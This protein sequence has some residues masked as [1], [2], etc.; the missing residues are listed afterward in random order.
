[1][2][3]DDNNV[4]NS[5][6]TVQEEDNFSMKDFMQLC[7]RQWPWFLC[8]L[9]FFIGFGL[10]YVMRQQPVYE[11]KCEVLI[12][13]NEQNSFGEVSSGFSMSGV[14]SSHT[15]VNNELISLTTPAVM[16]EVV[17]RLD[18]DM[19]YNKKG[20]LHPTT[21]YRSSNPII[22]EMPD[23][24]SEGSGGF[25]VELNPDGSAIMYKFWKYD[26]GAKKIVK[27]DKE[28]ACRLG[29][30]TLNTPI[31]RVSLQPN[32]GFTGKLVEPIDIKVSH[33]S[34]L[35]T[36]E[37]YTAR[38]NGDL[39]DQD[40]EVIELSLRDV[41][42]QRAD[43]ILD[44]VV[45]VYNE[46]WIADK[47]RVAVATSEF[48]D[49]RLKVIE[50][51]LGNV[52][53][54]V[55][56]FKA[57]NKMPDIEH[58]IEM[59]LKGVGDIATAVI[60][61]RNQLAMAQ[62]LKEYI[63]NPQHANDVVPLNIGLNDASMSQSINEFNKRLLERNAMVENSSTDNPLVKSADVE[64]RGL[65]KSILRSVD[66]QIGVLAASLR[67]IQGEQGNQD[68]MLE[69]A[70][71]QAKY[72][73]SIERQQK[74]KEELYVFLLQKREENELS[75]TFTAYNTRVITPPWG[76]L[77]PV[78]PRMKLTLFVCFV[79][80]LA[81]PV[82]VLYVFEMTNTKIRS[83]KDLE[84]IP[85]P[86]AGE[87]PLVGKKNL[88]KKIFTSP[89][90]RKAEKEAPLPVVKP[91]CRD[92]PNEA[93]R[94]VRSNI[95][96]IIGKKSGCTVMLLTSINPGSG[97]SFIAYNLGASFALKGKKVLL[98]DCD[99][100]HGSLSG[101]AN[102]PRKG[103][104][105]YLTGHTDDWQKLTVK[106]AG[107]DNLDIL[108]IG[109]RPPNPAELLDNGRLA[110]LIEE[111]RKTYDVVL[112]DC[113]PA[114]MLVDTQ[115]V[116]PYTDRTLFVVRA[117]LLERKGL[118]DIMNIYE[119]RKF[120]HLTLLLNGT[121]TAYSSYHSYGSYQSFEADE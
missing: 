83:R 48:I 90:K 50:S 63:N 51:E 4:K 73:L 29:F 5:G 101:Y 56:E 58:T 111:A 61:T 104:S 1:M 116:E 53:T 94:V 84:N 114:N 11:R 38:L 54:E 120:K 121:N 78:A 62:Y 3:M 44:A 15:S 117:G 76:S 89:N 87:I 96:F 102:S 59:K 8:S 2:D 10:L 43:D 74:V 110:T 91:G 107:M 80:A 66:N 9:I 20:L 57:R 118:N 69:N 112:I 115:I 100:R 67:D 31:G 17:D 18:L 34:F 95:D 30:K 88:L 72:L 37:S 42:V 64:L 19:N 7:L 40:A 79:L 97:K 45:N 99:L 55:S 33:S 39:V 93:F 113:P 41:C 46:R 108:G 14:F 81:L 52:D 106:N 109:H 92:I 105:T 36:V 77:E 60:E 49:E 21:L 23:L 24:G 65:R 98:I 103:V 6:R 27:F 26:G 22:V 86:F 68:R 28:I 35:A 12:A 119:S 13:D 75:Q 25:T 47:N 16:R 70:P 32:G 71:V 82:L 85:M